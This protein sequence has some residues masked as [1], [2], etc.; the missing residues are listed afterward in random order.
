MVLEG[1]DYSIINRVCKVE[2]VTGRGKHSKGGAVLFPKIK[3]Y[4]ESCG[5]RVKEGKDKG[6]LI[7]LLSA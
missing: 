6:K 3:S 4:L 2:I 1:S 7:A 5:Y